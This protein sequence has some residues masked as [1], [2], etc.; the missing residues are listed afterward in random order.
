MGRDIPRLTALTAVLLIGACSKSSSRRTSTPPP[1][2]SWRSL[3]IQ[4]V[5]LG[6][7]NCAVD[8]EYEISATKK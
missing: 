2:A 3:G 1:M 7:N 6:S 4:T 8:L 5:G